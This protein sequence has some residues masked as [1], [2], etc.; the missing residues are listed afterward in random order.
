MHRINR[1]FDQEFNQLFALSGMLR[2]L[3]IKG[4][5]MKLKRVD[6][7][8]HYNYIEDE[9]YDALIEKL[10]YKEF[11]KRKLFFEKKFQYYM[12]FTIER[13]H[14]P[15]LRSILKR[16]KFNFKVLRRGG[17]EVY[18]A[19]GLA[20][21]LYKQGNSYHGI[22]CNV[23]GKPHAVAPSWTCIEFKRSLK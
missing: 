8:L 16:N 20:V 3:R 4:V 17:I 7:R 6:K 18:L 19:N 21:L 13:W 23:L 22:G 12:V 10:L 5:T 9:Y 1:E 14:E 2:E 11:I 15:K